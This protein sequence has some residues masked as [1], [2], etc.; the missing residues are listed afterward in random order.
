MQAQER[1]HFSI[2]YGLK[3]NITV[4]VSKNTVFWD[5]M[6]YS[7]QVHCHFRGTCYLHFQDSIA[8]Q[9]QNHKEVGGKQN[10][11]F[12]SAYHLCLIRFLLDLLFNLE[13][14]GIVFPRN[15]CGIIPEYKP[16]H[17]RRHYSS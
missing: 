4:S 15:I 14:G 6:P 7:P 13:D 10:E 2:S 5:I 12:N 11:P 9:N 16:L 3:I 17:P 8:S 1:Y